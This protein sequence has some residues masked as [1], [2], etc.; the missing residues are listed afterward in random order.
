MALKKT[1][2]KINHKA[3]K[4]IGDRHFDSENSVENA[5]GATS[6]TEV[7]KEM[8]TVREVVNKE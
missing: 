2:G 7:G 6:E 1:T 8:E 4:P 5:T 3:G